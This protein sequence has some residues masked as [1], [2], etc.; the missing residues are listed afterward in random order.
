[1]TTDCHSPSW[2]MREPPATGVIGFSSVTVWGL[3][4]VGFATVI[5]ADPP[6]FGGCTA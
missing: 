3:D 1:M 4:A 2:E 6:T 5:V